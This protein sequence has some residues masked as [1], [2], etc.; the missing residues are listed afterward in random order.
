MFDC[1]NLLVDIFGRTVFGVFDIIFI[2]SIKIKTIGRNKIVIKSS[3]LIKIRIMI[4][5]LYQLF[6]LLNEC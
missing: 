3:L 4:S 6:E 2:F 5:S 1:V